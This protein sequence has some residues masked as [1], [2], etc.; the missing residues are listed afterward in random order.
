MAQDNEEDYENA[1]DEGIEITIY[2][3]L[4]D[5]INNNSRSKF[6]ISFGEYMKKLS[7]L[8]IEYN[9]IGNEET[10]SVIYEVAQNVMITFIDNFMKYDIDF[11]NLDSNVKYLYF[12]SNLI[13]IFTINIEL[14]PLKNIISS[15]DSYLKDKSIMEIFFFAFLD[16]LTSVI[17]K[18]KTE[19]LNNA[20]TKKRYL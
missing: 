7:T 12:F 10:Q 2:D 11:D 20:D 6:M 1:E 5:N 15:I 4:N 18:A 3:L 19:I 17:A 14:F 16:L 13:R 9:E 8:K